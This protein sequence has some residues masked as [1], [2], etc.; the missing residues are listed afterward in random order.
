[1]AAL[2]RVRMTPAEFKQLGET[3]QPVE[4]INGET[5]VTPAPTD[6]HQ[7]L[8]LPIA[9]LLKQLVPSGTLRVAP[10]DVWLDDNCVQPDVFWVSGADSSCRLGEDGYWYGAPD[11]VVE[12]I[13]P[14]T[15][16]KDRGVKFDLYENH[17]VREYWLVDP[18]G[19]YVEVYRREGER[20]NR[21]GV[22]AAGQSWASGVLGG[23]SI[24]AGTLLKAE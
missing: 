21:A 15:A 13:S 23:V 11:L 2:E 10:T 4:F 7:S 8:I 17:G 5:I 16:H 18:E 1:M 20:F 19:W 22:F 6:A 9:L 3:T 14:S 12:V 24:D